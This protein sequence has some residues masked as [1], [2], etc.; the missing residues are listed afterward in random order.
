MST[1]HIPRRDKAPRRSRHGR[2]LR[3]PVIPPSVPAWRTRADKFDDAV[4][5]DIAQF[6]LF[7]GTKLDHYDFAVL[8]MPEK[9][10]APWEKGI[11][12]GRFFPFERPAKIHG[13]IVFYRLPILSAARQESNFSLFLHQVITMHIASALNV[14][15]QAI[16]YLQ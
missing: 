6:R 3:G 7:L 10:P 14:D 9:A 12:L 2:S 5:S 1:L 16:D 4:A 8:D 11:P 15:P 13:R